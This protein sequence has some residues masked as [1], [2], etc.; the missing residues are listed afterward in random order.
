M[1]VVKVEL[2]PLGDAEAAE[3]L[4]VVAIMNTGP[5]KLAETNP[6]DSDERNYVV[7]LQPRDGY[8]RRAK[9]RHYRRR[10]WLTLVR[11]AL[12]ELDG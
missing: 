7:E 3:P 11:R 4:G 2:W 10:G 12:E 9:V 8:T 5:T 6:S 1:L